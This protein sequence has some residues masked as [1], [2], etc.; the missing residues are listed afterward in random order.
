MSNNTS[1]PK[2]LSR[3]ERR[4]AEE[5]E[6][7]KASSPF[8][9]PDPT[10]KLKRSSALAPPHQREPSKNLERADQLNQQ[11]WSKSEEATE[12]NKRAGSIAGQTAS[13]HIDK[14][15]FS[16]SSDIEEP[17]G[18]GKGKEGAFRDIERNAFGK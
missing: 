2:K 12:A 15:S 16:R 9:Q 5:E 11:F 10:Q 3:G 8:I 17:K 18:K 4:R 1:E 14:V 6:G 13:G 7:K